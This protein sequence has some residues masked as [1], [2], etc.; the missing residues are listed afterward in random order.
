VKESAGFSAQFCCFRFGRVVG[1]VW[2]NFRRAAAFWTTKSF[3]LIIL[4]DII[5]YFSDSLFW[6]R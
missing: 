5:S 6:I 2:V 1:V 3:H 4:R